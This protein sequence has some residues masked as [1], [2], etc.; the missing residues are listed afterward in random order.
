MPKLLDQ[1]S[2]MKLLQEHGWTIGKPGRHV[3]KMVKEGARPITLPHHR[4][5]VYGK[6]LTH[7]IIRQA[8]LQPREDGRWS[9]PSS[10]IR[11]QMA[12]GRRSTSYPDASRQAGR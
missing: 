12:S 2:A 6:G 10:Y 1:R 5:Q 3:V 7:A 4:G 9:S 11:S 8:E